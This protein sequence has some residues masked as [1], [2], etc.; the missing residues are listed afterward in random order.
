LPR[1]L[2]ITKDKRNKPIEYAMWGGIIVVLRDSVDEFETKR[3][4]KLL[5]AKQKLI[6]GGSQNRMD[7]V[8][9]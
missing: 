2:K 4:K 1:K 5:T 3:N 7:I 9:K 8:Q 6:M